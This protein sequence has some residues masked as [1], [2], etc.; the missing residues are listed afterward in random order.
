VSFEAWKR[1]LSPRPLIQQLEIRDVVARMLTFQESL[2]QRKS[3][4]AAPDPG[5]YPWDSFGTIT[6]WEQL[7]TGRYRFL[8][9]MI[10]SDP[11]LDIGCGDGDLSFF[12]ESLGCRVC[13]IDNPPTNYNRMGGVNAVKTALAS[14]VRI[15]AI[16]LDG[17]SSLPVR[18]AG[19]A[20]FC[21]IL[22]H[23]K[24][25]F[26]VL[27]KLAAGARYC[28][29]S[30]AITRTTPDQTMV[31]DQLPLA[32]LMGRDG[33]CGDETNYWIFSETGLRTLLDRT[34]WDVCVWQVVEDV[35]CATGN[36]GRDERVLCL[37]RS[38][39]FETRAAT[40]LID[41]WHVLEN[42]AWRWTEREFSLCVAGGGQRLSLAVTAPENLVL[43]LTLTASVGGAIIAT[44]R[45]DSPGNYECAQTIPAG[46]EVLVEF[47]LDYA[48][49][50]EAADQRE[51]G[52]VVRGIEVG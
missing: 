24:N 18:H 21:G 9:P 42:G 34:G 4:M 51:R 16:D 40:Q 8:E 46:E 15:E 19:L 26:G 25:P 39:S 43:P 29:L 33:L 30:T 41:G 23:L 37:L 2:T 27:E 35:E 47:S 3:E 31:V 5:W 14:S 7:L 13:A 32:F 12:F 36:S 22:Y 48:L 45:F 11:V 52:I 10:G 28:L 1:L 50:A 20:L 38:R 6:L 17:P 49:A 44:H